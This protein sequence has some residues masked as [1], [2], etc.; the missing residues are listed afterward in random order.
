MDY[1]HWAIAQKPQSVARLVLA[2]TRS[3]GGAPFDFHRY[4]GLEKFIPEV[5][6]KFGEE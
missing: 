1:L 5:E 3:G 4:C 6:G 2:T